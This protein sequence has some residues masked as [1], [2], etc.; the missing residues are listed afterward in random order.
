MDMTQAAFFL[1]G[2]ILFML[3]LVVIIS[4]A[5][6][7]NNLLHKFWKPVRIWRFETYPPSMIEPKVDLEI[8]KIDNVG[9]SKSTS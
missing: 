4:G 1:A 8:N 9:P 3:G 2:S 6:A 5:I 7:I